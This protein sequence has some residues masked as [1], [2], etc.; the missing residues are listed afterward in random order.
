MNMDYY[1]S[2]QNIRKILEINRIFHGEIIE[3]IRESIKNKFEDYRIEYLD[4]KISEKLWKSRIARDTIDNERHRSLIEV[5]E[6]YVTVTSDFIRQLAFEKISI[7]ELLK[8][9][10]KFYKYFEKSIDEILQIFGGNLN[11][12]QI[13]VV[14]QAKI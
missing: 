2:V 4:N 1:Y 8:N 7:N 13:T 10:S 6:M 14:N 3:N 12:R 11:G 9:Y 5:F